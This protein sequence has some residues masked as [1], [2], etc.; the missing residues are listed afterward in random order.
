MENFIFVQWNLLVFSLKSDESFP[1][2]EK[3]DITG[4]FLPSKNVFSI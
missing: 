3:G 1:S 4:I 2:M